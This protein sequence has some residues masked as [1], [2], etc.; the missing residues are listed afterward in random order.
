MTSGRKACLFSLYELKYKSILG[1]QRFLNLV[2]LRQAMAEFRCSL[3]PC[4]SHLVYKHSKTVF[5]Q[6]KICIGNLWQFLGMQEK[7]QS[8][9]LKQQPIFLLG[10]TECILWLL[11][12]IFHAQFFIKGSKEGYSLATIFWYLFLLFIFLQSPNGQSS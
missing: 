7:V 5:K 2:Q 9:P 8:S 3:Q 1:H 11:A 4:F 12:H 10:S 6:I